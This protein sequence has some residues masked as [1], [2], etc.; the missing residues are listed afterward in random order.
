MRDSCGT[1]G[2]VRPLKAHS[3][4]GLTACP[5]ESEQLER[6]STTSNNN[7]CENCQIKNHQFNF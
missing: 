1:S 4:K 6:K 7:V 2:Q 5:A 3:G